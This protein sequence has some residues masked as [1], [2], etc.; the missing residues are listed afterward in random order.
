MEPDVVLA[1]DGKLGLVD[2]SVGLNEQVYSIGV[3]DHLDAT[4]D[5]PGAW[6]VAIR[7][8]CLD[9]CYFLSNIGHREHEASALDYGFDVDRVMPS[10]QVQERA[11][12]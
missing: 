4:E 9:G 2:V 1:N 6:L 10:N 3:C 11:S 7:S 12:L 8:E 5:Q